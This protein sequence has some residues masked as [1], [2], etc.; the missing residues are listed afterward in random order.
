MC[1]Y[2]TEHAAVKGSGKGTDGWFPLTAV[3]MSYDHPVHAQAEHCVIIDFANLERG[4]AARVA[5]E[6]TTASALDLVASI[7]RVIDSVPSDLSGVETSDVRRLLDA[8]EQVTG[9]A[10]VTSW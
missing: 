9:A 6:L 3:T 7:A 5:V 4:P 1:T 2:V 10:K 8:A